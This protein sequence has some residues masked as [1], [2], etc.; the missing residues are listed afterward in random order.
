[1]TTDEAFGPVITFGAGGTMIELIADR[2]IELPPLNQ[3]LA[4]R[5]IER[6]RVHEILQEWRGAPAADMGALEQ[7]LLRVSDMVCMLPQL[8]QM[9]INPVIV[10]DQGAVAVDARIVVDGAAQ[11]PGNY[12]H[13]AVLPYPTGLEREWPLNGGGLYTI[14]PIHPDDAEMLQTFIRSLSPESRYFRFASALPELP[15]RMLAVSYTHLDVYKRQPT[16]MVWE[17]WLVNR[18]VPGPRFGSEASGGRFPPSVGVGLA[19]WPLVL[20]VEHARQNRMGTEGQKLDHFIIVMGSSRTVSYT[21]LDVYKRQQEYRI[22]IPNPTGSSAR[23]PLDRGRRSPAA[24]SSTSGSKTRYVAKRRVLGLAV[25]SRVTPTAM[26][27]REAA[28]IG[29]T[30]Q[31]TAGMARRFTSRASRFRTISAKTS[32]GVSVLLG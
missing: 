14:R 10:D 5:L 13:L 7:L 31:K 1:M 24:C 28:I 26:P 18:T 2:A 4:R 19:S 25:F 11:A 16:Q 23:L 17:Q 9:D 27:G 3:F 29:T 21:H 20:A 12:G 8:R 22:P 30:R 32:P 15:A 6:S